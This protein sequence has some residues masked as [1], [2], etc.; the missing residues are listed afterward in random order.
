MKGVQDLVTMTDV[1]EAFW[2]NFGFNK[3][4]LV[5]Q[6]GKLLMENGGK[7]RTAEFFLRGFL[8]EYLNARQPFDSHSDIQTCL[9][10]AAADL[11]DEKDRARRVNEIQENCFAFL[12]VYRSRV[13]METRWVLEGIEA[14]PPHVDFLRSV[15]EKIVAS[16]IERVEAAA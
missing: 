7:Q 13:Q 11:E 2:G 4:S 3:C 14:N 5:V 16:K 1:I 9:E 6:A 15:E 12:S 10:M 8:V